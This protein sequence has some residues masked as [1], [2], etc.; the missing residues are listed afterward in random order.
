MPQISDVI[1][2]V[3]NRIWDANT[4]AWIDETASAAAGGGLTD[5]ELRA[6]PV[7]VL[8][9]ID[10]TGLATSV[11]Q[12]TGNASLSSIDGK[13]PALG[14]AL[15]AASTPV[16]LPAA[17]ITTLT[18]PAAI[19]GFLSESDFDTKAGSLTEAAPAS[20]TASSGLNGRLQRI[21]QRLTALI[22]ALGSPFQAGASIGNTAFIANAGTNL[23]TSALA[24]DATLT[25]RLPAAAASADGFANPT[26]TQIGT[27][28]MLFNGA[29]WDRA[30]GNWRTT[31]GD[32]GAKTV[33]FNGATQT[34]FDAVGVWILIQLG[35]VSGTT[36]TF[37][38]Q[39]QVSYDAG[40]TFLNFGPA[41]A[42]LTASSQTG[43]IYLYPA[44]ISQAAGATPANMTAGATVSMF[45]NLSLPRTWRLQY[46]IGGTTPSFAMTA[47][48]VNYIR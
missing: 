28:L 17:Q 20:D 33:T 6:S 25:G 29:T 11:G 16:V 27:E 46:T 40:T 47:V 2:Y 21:A 23:N 8:A 37:A 14:Q 32:T 22:T 10:T 45:L 3:R 30:R 7:P 36:P 42:N 35:T 24:L 19:T 1:Q 41:L 48:H 31:T 5:A 44:N 39:L 26:I 13:T 15:A 18:P 9:T 4:L 43:S 38:A 12:T 34:N